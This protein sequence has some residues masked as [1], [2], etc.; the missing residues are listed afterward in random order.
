[1]GYK[2][3]IFDFDG[4]IIDSSIGTAKAFRKGL[5]VYDVDDTIENII[6]LI[7]PPLS[8]TIMTKYGFDEKM[9]DKAMEVMYDYLINEGIYECPLYDGV[10]EMIDTLK[11]NGVKVAIATS[12][13]LFTA[14]NHIRVVKM[15]G[16]F[17]V[18]EANNDT[19]TRGSKADLVSF[20]I[21]K[22]N[23]PKESLLMTGDRAVDIVG[24][25]VNGLK[26]AAVLYGFGSREEMESAGPDYFVKKP[27]DF[28]DI[29]L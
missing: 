4:T 2:G 15:E 14:M 6:S 17:D 8:Q 20:A 29:V 27:L 18:F 12:Q 16:V 26:T 10:K 22:L 24:G 1:M 3:V 9:R 25:R 5:N 7:G 19:Q 28:L 11:E 13:P 23:L 21:E